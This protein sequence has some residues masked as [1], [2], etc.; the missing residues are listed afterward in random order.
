YTSY[1][2]FVVQHGLSSPDLMRQMI[3]Q[4]DRCL[5]DIRMQNRITQYQCEDIVQLILGD[6]SR[7]SANTMCLNQ[8][9]VRLEDKYPYCGL[10]WPYELPD[11]K[12]YLSRD[13]VRKALHATGAVGEW[14]E[15]N[16]RVGSALRFDN[17][18]PSF[19]LL[20]GI[21]EKVKLMLYSGEQ[22]LICNHIGTE[23]LISNLI[24][25][26]ARG[27]QNAPQISWTVDEKPAGFWRQERDLTYVLLYNASHMVPYDTPLAAADMMRRF[28]ELDS[29][30]QAFTS[31]LG[32]DENTS[33]DLP[34]GGEKIDIDQPKK[35]SS[36][37]GPIMLITVMAAIGA[38]I[39]A[40]MRYNRRQK[41]LGRGRDG[42]Q[43]FP[44]SSNG[45]AGRGHE[46]I[47]DELD[48]LVVEGRIHS[49]E[50]DEDEDEDEV[51]EEYRDDQRH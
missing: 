24:W 42:V 18:Q 1:I 39:F 47:L 26:G 50:D 25:Q 27:F 30:I 8:Y 28:M 7:K 21:L 35:P 13:D 19:T 16:S 34:P 48:E 11:M 51:V 29:K 5:D 32:T 3:S 46:P 10:L 33:D 6:S 15:C 40:I 31:R 49:D 43:W 12:A 14:N 36:S 38:S 9:D 17:T 23:N 22:D 41:S 2:P 4:Q 37:T 45:S 20:P 44:L